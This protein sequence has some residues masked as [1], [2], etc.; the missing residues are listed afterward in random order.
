M[1]KSLAILFVLFISVGVVFADQVTSAP[2]NI[3][4]KALYSAPDENSNVIF[5]LPVDVSLVDVSEDGNWYKVKI[6]YN[7]GPLN[8]TYVGWTQ[9]PVGSVLASRAE[10]FAKL[11][12]DPELQ[13]ENSTVVPSSVPQ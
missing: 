6:A 9:I 3:K 5:N 2:Y 1:K 11:V 10:R 7:L 4:V 12:S 8:Y 13:P